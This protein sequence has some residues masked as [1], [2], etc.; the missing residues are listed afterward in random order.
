MEHITKKLSL[1]ELTELEKSNISG[2]EPT[3]DTP[4]W[5]DVA[6]VVVASFKIMAP[7]RKATSMTMTY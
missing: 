5:Y 4:F 1:I 3:P 2:G 7:V 6:W